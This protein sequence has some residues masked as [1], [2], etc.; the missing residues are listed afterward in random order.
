MP[1]QVDDVR[2]REIK[3]LAPP[4]HLLREFPTSDR[5]EALAYNTRSAIHRVL[6]GS[7]DRLVVVIGPC[8][9]H[10][11]KAGVEYARRLR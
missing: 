3:E 8:S 7:D 10:D 4:S 11:P 6:H 9:M 1:Y 2:I 5:T